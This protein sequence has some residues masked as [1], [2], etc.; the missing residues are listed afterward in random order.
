MNWAT[1]LHVR[2]CDAPAG[3]SA[4]RV[5]VVVVLDVVVSVDVDVDVFVDVVVDVVVV[6]RQTPHLSRL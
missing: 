4:H 2:N 3:L 6:F 1:R 5:D